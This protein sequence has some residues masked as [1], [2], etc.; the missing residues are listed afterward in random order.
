MAKTPLTRGRGFG[1]QL[2]GECG[3]NSRPWWL[4]SVRGYAAHRQSAR[5]PIRAY[6]FLQEHEGPH[7]QLAPHAQLVVWLFAL[8]FRQPQVQAA[9][10]HDRH[11]HGLELFDIFKLLGVL[12]CCQQPKFRI[13]PFLR[14]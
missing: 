6:D 10:G 8:A 7:L 1:M 12:T 13:E 5:H 2:K 3:W 4:P 11:L 14:H 9:S